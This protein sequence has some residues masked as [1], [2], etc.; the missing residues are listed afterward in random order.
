MSTSSPVLKTTN[1][2]YATG[3]KLCL[4][5]KFEGQENWSKLKDAEPY[6]HNRDVSLA[7]QVLNLEKVR[8]NWILTGPKKYF[9]AQ[10]RI[11]YYDILPSREYAWYGAHI[12]LEGLK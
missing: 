3:S 11:G 1:P 5:V 12:L 9:G 6:S 8:D 2:K 10:Y 7:N 4:E